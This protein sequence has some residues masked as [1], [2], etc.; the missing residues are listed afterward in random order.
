MVSPVNIPK[1]IKSLVQQ[2]APGAKVLLFGSR[3]T[4]TATDESDWDVL[5]LTEQAVNAGL[6]KAVHKNVFPLSVEIGSFINLLMVQEIDW[7]NNP[8]YYS[9]QQTIVAE[10][11]QA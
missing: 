1:R 10:D 8:S 2:A 3:V 5:V 11:I 7:Q 9:L 4:G 6:K